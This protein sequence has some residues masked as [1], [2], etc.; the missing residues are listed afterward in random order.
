MSVA[1]GQY[2]GKS[3][4]IFEDNGSFGLEVDDKETFFDGELLKI[5]YEF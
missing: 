4:D 5:G 3:H 1:I 2:F